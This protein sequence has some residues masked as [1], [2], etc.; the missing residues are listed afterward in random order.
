MNNNKAR[1][2]FKNRNADLLMRELIQIPRKTILAVLAFFLLSFVSSG[3]TFSTEDIDVCQ[4]ASVHF[5]KGKIPPFFV[6]YGGKSSDSFITSWQYSSEKW[7]TENGVEKY[8]YNYSDKKAVSLYKCDVTC[9]TRF[10]SVEWIGTFF[11][12]FRKKYPLIEKARSH[13]LFICFGKRGDIYSSPRQ[14]EQCQCG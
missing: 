3:Q 1:Y 5:A 8:V 12:Y 14:W 7:K 11:K 2:A 4:W 6:V 10:Q 13:S 9:Y